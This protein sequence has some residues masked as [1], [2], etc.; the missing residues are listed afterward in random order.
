MRLDLPEQVSDTVVVLAPGAGG[1]MNSAHIVAIAKELVS[2]GLGVAR[3][4][5]PYRQAGRSIPDPM[6]KLT[7]A[8]RDGVDEVRRQASPKKLVIGGH[9]MGGRVASMLAS[10][11]FAADGL[12]LLS[13]PWA[14]PGKPEKARTEHLFRITMPVLC[15]SGTRDP[16]VPHEIVAE[17]L[18]N[19]PNTFDLRWIEGA[20]HSLHIAKSALP[21]DRS[22]E[23]RSDAEVRR[24]VADAIAEWVMKL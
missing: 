21:S 11:G 14:P 16:F 6:P 24:D 23:W 4:D 17:V 15:F 20:D 8:Y 18:P 12:L 2:R 5:F 7:A 10:E 9:S 1:S 3:F 13:Y 19:L 22:G